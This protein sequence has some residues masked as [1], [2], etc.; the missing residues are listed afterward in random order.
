MHHNVSVISERRISMATQDGLL[1]LAAANEVLTNEVYAKALKRLGKYHMQALLEIANKGVESGRLSPLQWKYL[2]DLVCK[3]QT[4]HSDIKAEDKAVT[5][6]V[7]REFLMRSPGKVRFLARGITLQF[8]YA[9]AAYS[10]Q[11]D[12]FAVTHCRTHEI[13]IYLGRLGTQAEWLP[14]TSGKA[15]GYVAAIAE[16]ARTPDLCATAYGHATGQCS[17]CARPLSDDRSVAVGYGPICADKYGLPWSDVDTG[18]GS[19]DDNEDENL[20]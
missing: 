6:P 19:V 12:T 9:S 18:M 4:L 16:I 17:F 13:E 3:V 11:P 15:V 10:S 20:D 1:T 5:Y 7:L 8:K 14:N 2:E